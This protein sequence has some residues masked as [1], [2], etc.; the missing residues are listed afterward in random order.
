MSTIHAASP[1][2]AVS[3]LPDVLPEDRFLWQFWVNKGM[4]AQ[5]LARCLS[6]LGAS[7]NWNYIGGNALYGG[8]EEGVLRVLSRPG[9][10]APSAWMGRMRRDAAGSA[11]AVTPATVEGRLLLLC[12][13][14]RM[15][16]AEDEEARRLAAGLVQWE[17]VAA[18]AARANLTP[19]VH[20]N[21]VRIG[22][23]ARLPREQ[24]EVLAARSRGIASRNRR[25][26]GQLEELTRRL[27]ADGI[28]VL[29]L[30][31]SALAMSHYGN[32]RL[33]MMGDIDLLLEPEQ[34]ERVVVM[35]ESAGYESAEVLWTKE[36]YRGQHHHAAPLV[37]PDLA[38]KIEPHRSFALPLLAGPSSATTAPP[39]M[40]A[41]MASRAVRLDARTWCFTPAD[42]LFHLCLDLWGN[43]F[44]GKM[45]QLCDA[46]EV[47][48]QGGVEWPM[49]EDLARSIGAEAH[50]GFSLKLLAD[51]DA[52]V[53]A[54][55]LSRLAAAR[56]APFDA[57]RLRSM[58][59]RNLFGYVPARARLSRAGEKLMFQAL[60]QPGGWPA[61]AAFLV[62][63]YLYLGENR[64]D[65]GDLGRRSR[66]TTGRA[67]GRM[68][69]LPLRA[70][71][72]W[73]GSRRMP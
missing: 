59:E 48:R 55:V 13:S 31:E 12:A 68:L 67:I 9:A 21:L 60:G 25:L 40:V 1:R 30:K 19:C 64:E 5:P 49:L 52:P 54:E 65:I 26:V 66:P 71:K 22:L 70:V 38:A 50:L 57:R 2:G 20:H 53:P 51:L 47:I 24:A 43:A 33:R 62:R 27:E 58:A 35:L 7:A 44:L 29:L 17:A 6:A 23:D 69:T 61:R 11:H 36:H 18:G 34:I 15:T 46:R 56:P 3:F 14:P 42:T 39:E 63:R 4:E 8:F 72:R 37:H 41:A 16:V 32:G 28:R 10:P 45:G 73:T